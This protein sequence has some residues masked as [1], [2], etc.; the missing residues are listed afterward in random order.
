MS[1]QV[2]YFYMAR[3]TREQVNYKKNVYHAGGL[4]AVD[5]L[6]REG[7]PKKKEYAKKMK[8]QGFDNARIAAKEGH[9]TFNEKTGAWKG[10]NSNSAEGRFASKK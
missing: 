7:Y 4:P 6:E 9:G 8:G 5:K 2:N 3:L 1:L 10:K